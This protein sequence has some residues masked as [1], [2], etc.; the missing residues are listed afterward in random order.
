MENKILKKIEE[1]TKQF[2]ENIK[3]QAENTGEA[4]DVIQK[5]LS[6]VELTDEDEEVL[7]TQLVDWLKIFGVVIPFVLIPGASI[8]MPFLIKVANKYNIELMPTAF[9][10]K[11]KKLKRLPKNKSRFK[12]KQK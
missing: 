3:E 10:S 11:E 9:Q 8:L 5:Y 4:S 7:K 2:L 1:E 12:W 6:G